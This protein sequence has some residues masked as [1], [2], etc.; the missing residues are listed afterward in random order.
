M[1]N[2]IKLGN[3]VRDQVTGLEGYAYQMFTK[4][5]GTV[6]FAIQP[7]CKDNVLP[8]PVFV[9]VFTLV[10]VNDGV[11]NIVPAIDKHFIEFGEHVVDVA[12]KQ[13][14]IV[15]GKV[16]YLNGCVYYEVTVESVDN[17]HPDVFYCEHKRLD[18]VQADINHN[19]IDRVKVKSAKTGGPMIRGKLSN[20]R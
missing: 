6:Q 17:K 19:I 18:V 3:Y 20:V 4:L 9:D 8:D 12:S 16:I 5:N 15:T 13:H 14:G 2:A 10:Y 7:V 11:A 1:S